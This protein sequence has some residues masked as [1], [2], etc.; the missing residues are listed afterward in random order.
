MCWDRWIRCRK[1]S[2]CEFSVALSL[3]VFFSQQ[4]FQLAPFW[5]NPYL[6]STQQQH[7]HSYMNNFFNVKYKMHM[8][9]KLKQKQ[10]LK[11]KLKLKIDL[12]LKSKLKLCK[13]FT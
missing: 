10:K 4:S 11:L 1:K 9:R 3:T 8:V 5:P 12:K 7:P 13:P 2:I 6:P